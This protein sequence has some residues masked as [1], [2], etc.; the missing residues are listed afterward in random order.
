[1]EVTEMENYNQN[2]DETMHLSWFFFLFLPAAGNNN[3]VDTADALFH[4]DF[5]GSIQIFKVSQHIRIKVDVSLWKKK[6]KKGTSRDATGPG[7]FNQIFSSNA[8]S[9]TLAYKYMCAHWAWIWIHISVSS[10]LL[11]VLFMLNLACGSCAQQHAL[12]LKLRVQC[13]ASVCHFIT[14]TLLQCQIH[15]FNS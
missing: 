9:Y 11:S 15:I 4:L 14:L 1:M 12:N 8:F 3:V 10:V 2:G 7:L 5:D 13:I 6:R